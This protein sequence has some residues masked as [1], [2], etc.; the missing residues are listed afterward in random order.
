MCICMC[1]YMYIIVYTSYIN[2]LNIKILYIKY[3]VDFLEEL[4]SHAN[5]CGKTM[6]RNKHAVDGYVMFSVC[7]SG[8]GGDDWPPY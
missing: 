6:A 2:T 4:W 3:I 8:V 5:M 1:I 7:L